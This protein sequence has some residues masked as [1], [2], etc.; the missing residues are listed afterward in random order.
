MKSVAVWPNQTCLGKP[1]VIIAYTKMEGR[2]FDEG[3]A[4]WESSL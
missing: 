4:A 2:T 1:T 3:T